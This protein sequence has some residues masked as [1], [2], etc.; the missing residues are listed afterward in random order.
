MTCI[1]SGT[2]LRECLRWE[3][4]LMIATAVSLLGSLPAVAMP[5]PE[6]PMFGATGATVDREQYQ[7]YLNADKALAQKLGKRLGMTINYDHSASYGDLV[8]K[9]VDWKK[10]YGSFLAR[11]TPYA[12]V[13]ARMLGAKIDPLATYESK[14][15]NSPTYHSY[16][17]VNK[18]SLQNEF[19]LWFPRQALRDPPDLVDL[20]IYLQSLN[21]SP[22][23]LA[24]HVRS[25]K[26]AKDDPLIPYLQTRP[27]RPMF[28]FTEKYS[29]SSYF[30][31]ALWFSREH[32]FNMLR[33]KSSLIAIEAKQAPDNAIA[34]DLVT[35]VAKGEAQLAAVWDATKDSF[36]PTIPLNEELGK[37]VFFIQLPDVLP[38]DLLVCARSLDQKTKQQMIQAI[39]SM[40]ESPS[41]H[42]NIGDFLWWMP[43]TSDAAKDAL[44]A[45]AKL[46]EHAAAPPE[47][48]RV[49]IVAREGDHLEDY[50]DD[51]RRAVLYSG[52]EFIVYEPALH[53]DRWDVRWEL[54]KVHDG[55]LEL[56]TELRRPELKDLNQTFPISLRLPTGDGELTTRIVGLIRTRMNRSRYLWPYEDQPTIIRDVEFGV[57]EGSKVRVE[58]IEWDDAEH[59]Q[60][61][62]GNWTDATVGKVTRAKIPL[63]DEGLNQNTEYSDPMS[64][65]AFR[66]V[67]PRASFESSMT[68]IMTVAFLSVLMLAAAGA[69]FDLR[70]RPVSP[71][72]RSGGATIDRE[73]AA[74]VARVHD[75]WRGRQL[76]DADVIWCDRDGIERLIEELKIQGV[77]LEL[78][79]RERR[80]WAW[81]V[82][83][84]ISLKGA[85]GGSEKGGSKDVVID[86]AKVGD[87]ARLSA[88][89]KLMIERHLLST[90]VGIP[91]E[92]EALNRITRRTL[93][94]EDQVEA[95]SAG[96]D[97]IRTDDDL[98]LGIMSDHFN[99][100]LEDARQSV[101][102]F[103]GSWTILMQNGQRLAT[104]RVPL[105]GTLR[106]GEEGRAVHGLVLE[107]DLP[108]GQRLHAREASRLDCWLLG[109]VIDLSYTTLDATQWLRLRFRA[110]GELGE[111]A[112]DQRLGTGA[113]LIRGRGPGDPSPRRI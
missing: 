28:V 102:F 62:P 64:N 9:L 30:L 110:I 68:K 59:N 45:L 85:G 52:T 12:Y 40:A 100:V 92:V 80:T 43:I 53:G 84:R 104:Q 87:V 47:R 26:L 93:K 82:S 78:G 38:N 6:I 86:R 112:A 36:G 3:V 88:L 35:S 108:E 2:P 51:V 103:S 39:M 7:E 10:E 48:V 18:Q 71:D 13:A 75:P 5:P 89:L 20:R 31:P 79:L 69:I 74:L 96:A 14:A 97:L 61:S 65:V 11:I 46:E 76:A 27:K 15:T 90:F 94:P 81:R 44:P 72:Q 83:A 91:L 77:G 109:K 113:L 73:C 8:H 99:Q 33:P 19:R 25:L 50:L 29:S 56:V 41:E 32:I 95:G 70:R 63:S 21:T 55:S 106:I 57:E 101:S 111:S 34:A 49:R 24:D 1:G 105:S 42:I 58:R 4:L 60:V 107:F 16:F 67:L 22:R 54:R 23:V 17:V 98:I 37:R 66:V